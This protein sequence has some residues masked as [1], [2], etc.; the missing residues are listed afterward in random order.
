MTEQKTSNHKRKKKKEEG[1]TEILQKENSVNRSFR[2]SENDFVES[3]F[4]RQ[5]AAL[6]ALVIL[7]ILC[8]I[9]GVRMGEISAAVICVIVFIELLMG[10]F[11]GNEPAF[12]SIILTAIMVLAGMLTGTLSAVAPGCIVFIGT[13][14]VVKGK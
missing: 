14:L 5:Q 1:V 13:V 11:L 8:I 9:G 6:V 4:P 3:G 12:I 7:A 2:T 10:F